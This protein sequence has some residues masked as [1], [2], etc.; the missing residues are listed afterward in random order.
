MHLPWIDKLF[1]TY[2]APE[3]KWPTGYGIAGNPV[4]EGYLAQL[5]Y[6]VRP[7]QARQAVEQAQ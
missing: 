1:G 2:Y 3:G 6:P 4:P 5:T 7:P